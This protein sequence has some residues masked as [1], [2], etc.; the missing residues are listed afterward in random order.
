MTEITN[1]AIERQVRMHGLQ[2]DMHEIDD[3]SKLNL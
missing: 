2:S 3:Y 1:G